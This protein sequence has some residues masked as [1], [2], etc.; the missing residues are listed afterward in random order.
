MFRWHLG[1]P[2]MPIGRTTAL[3]LFAALLPDH[4]MYEYWMNQ[5]KEWTE[6][7]LA[8]NTSPG[9]A[10][11]EPPTDLHVDGQRWMAGWSDWAT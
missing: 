4:P 11:F 5:M 6:F 8:I 9:G 7:R 2:N 10:W 3:V 1:N